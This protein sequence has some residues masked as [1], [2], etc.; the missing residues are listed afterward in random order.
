MPFKH[1]YETDAALKR[2]MHP[3]P[4]NAPAAKLTPPPSLP[5]EQH[6]DNEPEPEDV[7]PAEPEPKDVTPIEPFHE[8]SLRVMREN[9]AVTNGTKHLMHPSVR[10]LTAQRWH[11]T[12]AAHMGASKGC[13][14]CAELQGSFVR[15]YKNPT[16]VTYNL[17]GHDWCLDM[18][19]W[20]GAAIDEHGSRFSTCM[21][22]M[23][24]TVFAP[25][26]HLVRRD[27]ATEDLFT[28]IDH[29]RSSPLFKNLPYPM[30][31]V[32]HLDNAGEWS[33]TNADFQRMIFERLG[34]R[35]KYTVKG[36]HLS[37]AY[38]DAAVKHLEITTK[39]I[40]LQSN[41]PPIWVSRCCDQA[42]MSRS[43]HIA[44]KHAGTD[45]TGD[46]PL[47]R[48]AGGLA[49]TTRMNLKWLRWTLPVGTP[50]LVRR[51]GVLGSN[52]T[53]TKA[54]IL[55]VARQRPF[56][57]A[58]VFINPARSWKL[59]YVSKNFSAIELEPHMSYHHVT[60]EKPPP[61]HIRAARLPA[62][63]DIPLRCVI[64]LQDYTD[65]RPV[66]TKAVTRIVSGPNTD[67]IQEP[68]VQFAL[69]DG[70]LLRNDHDH[71]LQ[72]STRVLADSEGALPPTQGFLENKLDTDSHWFKSRT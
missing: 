4:T 29:M 2:D 6:A 62:V 42:A 71:G 63:D 50:C 35:C 51:W 60:G 48:L 44:Q 22:D 3:L 57:G 13:R 26:N 45:G 12:G 31:Q 9:D 20:S 32:L 15:I 49:Y 18:I 1:E 21:R 53:E 19:Y 28:T 39:S 7:A 43:R 52:I 27:T 14:I 59:E 8:A 25:P 24:T 41:L 36:D 70:R 68:T 58:L 11:E 23:A 47:V 67:G 56:D 38:L 54:R 61:K 46:A 17:P 34:A 16:H 37:A 55:V 69:P 64:K 66:T 30:V 33:E 5:P 40:Q 65:P 72:P 10:K